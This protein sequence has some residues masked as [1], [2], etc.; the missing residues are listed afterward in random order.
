MCH[1]GIWR[2]PTRWAIDLTHGRT[3][4]YVRSAI[5]A[6]LSGRWQ[7]SHLAWKI[8]AI[9]F[10]NV[11]A[12]VSAAR[13][14]AGPASP[15]P[16]PIAPTLPYPP[17]ISSLLSRTSSSKTLLVAVDSARVARLLARAIPPVVAIN[18]SDWFARK[19]KAEKWAGF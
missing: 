7:A 15:A 16:M 8:G 13:E 10:V 14:T 18:Y 6:M 9:S 12:A 11:G 2:L 5:G 19:A 3:S 1:G 17:I 4:S